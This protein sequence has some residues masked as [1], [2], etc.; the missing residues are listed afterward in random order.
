[1]R[2]CV[3]RNSKGFDPYTSFFFPTPIYNISI[4]IN[5]YERS[6]YAVPPS[7]PGRNNIIS[8]GRHRARYIRSFVAHYIIQY[9]Y[10]YPGI[11]M[12]IRPRIINVFVMRIYY[13]PLLQCFEIFRTSAAPWRSAVMCVSMSVSWLFDWTSPTGRAVSENDLISRESHTDHGRETFFNGTSQTEQTI[14]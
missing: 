1:V 10:Q 2:L 11:C 7:H 3:P 12:Y 13:H 9:I 4:E 6:R 14:S 8:H 5:K